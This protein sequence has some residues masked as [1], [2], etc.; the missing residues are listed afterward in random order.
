MIV[1]DIMTHPALAIDPEAPLLQAIRLMTGHRVSGLPVVGPQGQLVGILTEGD[2]L[3]RA[4]TGTA[5]GR[6]GWLASF[7]LPGRT[8][9]K[10]VATHGRR[11]GEVM[12]TDVIA[13]TEDTSLAEAVE[14]MQR[15]R[16][17]RLPVVRDGRLLGVVSRAD[18]VRQLGEILAAAAPSTDDGALRQAVLDAVDREPWAHGRM[19]S[20][21]AK[22]GVVQL[23]GC[24]F[25]MNA[26][27]AL[28]VLAESVPGVQ[29][30]ENRIVCIEPY[31]GMVTYDPAARTEG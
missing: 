10:Y 19:V 17:R 11:V 29:R 16:V 20:I 3:R 30:V 14:L 5:G 8:A 21:T 12:T 7:L 23:D 2:L 9:Q 18:L 28:G 4:E 31:S 15:H 27:E 1:A 26:R 22:D 13:V 24:L 6:P 25:D